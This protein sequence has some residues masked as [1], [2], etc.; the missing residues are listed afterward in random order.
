MTTLNREIVTENKKQ[1]LNWMILSRQIEARLF[2][3]I[4]FVIALVY[5]TTMYP[6]QGWGDDFAQY[7]H[8]AM[9]IVQG[10]SMQETGYIYS[11]YTPQ[12]GPRVYPPGFPLL[13]A[14]V[15]ALFGLDIRAFQIEIVLMQL[16]SLLVIYRL[17]RRDT[18]HPTALILL[19]MMGLSP[20][21]VSFK[22][23]I[24]S[25]VPFM[26]FCVGFL[27]WVD[28]AYTQQRFTPAS[29]LVAVL[30]AFACYLV[31]TIG[32]V[33]LAAL[34]LSDVIRFRRP[35]RFAV[36][37]IGGTFV[38]ILVSRW[39]F[40]GGEESYLDQ[41]ANYTPQII[42]QNI[43]HYLIKSIRGFWAGPSITYAQL[44]VPIL[45]LVAIP[46]VIYGFMRRARRSSLLIELFFVFYLATI[47][48]WPSVQ[49]LRFLYPILPLFLLYVG[50]GFEGVFEQVRR[51][52]NFRV[53]RGIAII[54]A[55]AIL[56]IYAV[57]TGDVIASEGFL[58]EG[59]YTQPA[60]G[61]FEY[62]RQATSDNAI[63]VFY[64]PR[65]LSLYTNRAA[66]TFPYTA[67]TFEAADYLSELGADYAIVKN[68]ESRPNNVLASFIDA[69]PAAF[70][71]VFSNQDFRVYRIR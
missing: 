32:L 34:L 43:D 6:D 71:L 65:A 26:L 5:L 13:L 30:L 15:Y 27:L 19:I 37:I 23:D 56:S 48:I 11:R 1:P 38:L 22:R 17:Y 35:T 67:S 40:G 18:T 70:E 33:A 14:P 2:I 54:A 58:T 49:E 50:I 63:F 28:V 9:N 12:L 16:V 3:I 24:M 62:I 53:A 68:D 36:S 69:R 7:I 29:T 66:S 57:R 41:F 55:L 21:F 42:I 52:A 39:V 64:K 59:P 4:F 61:L 51:R 31:R 46:L 47:L 60:Q 45:W 25:D 8:Q 44:T 10:K 20:Y